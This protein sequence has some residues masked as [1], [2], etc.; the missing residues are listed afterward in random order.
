MTMRLPRHGLAAL[1]VTLSLAAC[2]DDSS[3]SAVSPPPLGAET[4]DAGKVIDNAIGEA[5]KALDAAGQ[6]AEAIGGRAVKD[7]GKALGPAGEKAQSAAEEAARNAGEALQ[8]A[9]EAMKRMGEQLQGAAGNRGEGTAQQEP[10][11]P[12]APS[13]PGEIPANS[14]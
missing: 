4:D 7:T 12:D 11:A 8:R 1:L 9:G 10:P 6:A 2:G 5:K 3:N 14:L 13:P